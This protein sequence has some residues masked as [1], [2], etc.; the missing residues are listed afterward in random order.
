MISRGCSG[1]D[2]TRPFPEWKIDFRETSSSQEIMAFSSRLCHDQVESIIRQTF[3][4][5]DGFMT[6]CR[7]AIAPGRPALEEGCRL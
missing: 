6:R 1:G 7:A 4:S 3:E 2:G 5:L